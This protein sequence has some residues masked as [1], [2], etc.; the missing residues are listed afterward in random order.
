MC[1]FADRGFAGRQQVRSRAALAIALVHANRADDALALF[2]KPMRNLRWTIRDNLY[3]EAHFETLLAL[4][5][6][7]EVL[8]IL[9]DLLWN[10]REVSSHMLGIRKL[11]QTRVLIATDEFTTAHY[12]VESAIAGFRLAAR[13]DKLPP[14]LIIL[15][16]LHGVS[17][18]ETENELNDALH[19]A[20]ETG[21][22][23]NQVESHIALAEFE[24]RKGD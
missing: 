20:Q 23:V 11:A 14:A 16:Q 13:K 17:W 21:H 3:T 15:A 4:G 24:S 12:S 1:E 9:K 18:D 6:H 8:K 22:L 2:D 10:G 5:H 7:D 19:I